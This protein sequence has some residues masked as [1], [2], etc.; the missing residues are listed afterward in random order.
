VVRGKPLKILL[1]EDEA[2]SAIMLAIELKKFGHEVVKTVSTGEAAVQSLLNTKPDMILMDVRLAG[3]WDGIETAECIRKTSVVPIVFTTGYTIRELSGRAE[4]LESI[5][6]VSKPMKIENLLS[7][8]SSF[9][10]PET[11]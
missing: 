11:P 9:F 6:Y 3:K 7:A 4:K 8:V 10:K 5:R 1:V 2:I